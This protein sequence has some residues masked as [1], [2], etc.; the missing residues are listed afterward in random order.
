M[1]NKIEISPEI[2]R[3]TQIRS[4][5]A[6]LSFTKQIA[7]CIAEQAVLALDPELDLLLDSEASLAEV[8]AMARAVAVND[9]VVNARHIDVALLETGNGNVRMP[10]ALAKTT[11]CECGSLVV[12]MFGTTSGAVVGYVDAASWNAAF[13]AKGSEEF[14][15]VPFSAQAFNLGQCL[16]RIESDLPTNVNKASRQQA[17]AE[18]YVTFLR[19]RQTL[20]V[21]RQRQVIESAIASAAV[22]ENLAAIST[23]IPD[24]LPRVL[25]QSGVWEARVDQVVARLAE[26]FPALKP[27][28]IEATVRSVGEKFGGQPEA[29]KFKEDLIKALAKQEFNFRFSP[30]LRAAASAIIDRVASGKKAVEAVKDFVKNQVA[31]DIASIIK[32]TRQDVHSFAAATAEEIGFAFQK[33]ALQPAYATHSPGE[34]SGVE[35]INE[36]LALMEA[37]QLVEELSEIDL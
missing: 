7:R 19:D 21:E 30:E 16:K 13:D 31:V 25:R 23:V 4:R 34:T 37:A 12:Q 15:E 14:V 35:D 24:Q 5:N 2:A 36:A 1:T 20:P 32:D 22:R 26:K 8:D 17:K 11:Y 29:L 33:L 28:Q 10:A 27:A 9:I 6:N 3:L 18:D